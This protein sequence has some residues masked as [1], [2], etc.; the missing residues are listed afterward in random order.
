MQKNQEKL[1]AEENWRMF[2]GENGNVVLVRAKT[3]AGSYEWKNLDDL[4]IKALEYLK[5]DARFEGIH[6]YVDERIA[7]I[8]GNK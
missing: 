5:T 7:I 1:D 6:K 4:T 2:A 3:R 8:K